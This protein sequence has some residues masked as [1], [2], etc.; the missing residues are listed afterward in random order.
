[1]LVILPVS[2]MHQTLSTHV[3]HCCMGYVS[4]VYLVFFLF[5]SICLSLYVSIA[6]HSYTLVMSQPGLA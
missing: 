3:F 2:L 6:Y 5:L 4:C 1:M